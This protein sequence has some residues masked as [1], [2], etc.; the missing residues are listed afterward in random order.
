MPFRQDTTYK[1][2]PTGGNFNKKF[3]NKELDTN[4]FLMK[5]VLDYLIEL[6]YTLGHHRY[7][8][9]KNPIKPEYTCLILMDVK[10]GNMC[11]LSFYFLVGIF[12]KLN[13]IGNKW[14]VF[15]TI[16]IYFI[17]ILIYHIK[18][19]KRI[20]PTQLKKMVEKMSDKERKGNIALSYVYS[21]GT[22]LLWIL[23][24]TWPL[25]IYGKAALV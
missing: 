8:N 20:H 11:I 17:L 6:D 16:S 4:P 7:Y 19:D 14:F 25:I 13:L 23:A 21:L 22:L 3:D 1:H 10:F 9:Q 24:F 15:F 2:A 18:I 12:R 5:N